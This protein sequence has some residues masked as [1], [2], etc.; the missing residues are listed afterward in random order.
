MRRRAERAD[1]AV[2]CREMAARSDEAARDAREI[3][4]HARCAQAA[5]P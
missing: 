2:G 3:L 4:G 5:G 1:R